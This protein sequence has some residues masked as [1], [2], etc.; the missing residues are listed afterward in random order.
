[1][2]KF[3]ALLTVLGLATLGLTGCMS[4]GAAGCTRPAPATPAL[5]GQFDISGDLG[6]TPS[7]TFDT[8][9]YVDEPQ[10]WETIEGT[11]IPI[12]SDNQ[13]V[14]LDVAVYDGSTGR[15]LVSTAFD[16]DPSRVFTIQD[17]TA[18]FPDFGDLMTCA[19]EGSRVAMALPYDGLSE[20]TAQG[21]GMSEG[22]S[23]LVVA[24]VTKAFLTR[25]TG[26][27]VFNNAHNLPTVVRAPSGQPGIIVPDAPAPD[28]IV[29]QTII[30]GDGAVLTADDTVRVNYTGVPWQVDGD[31][32]HTTWGD[33]PESVTV[34][35]AQQPGFTDALTDQTVG[36]QVLLVVPADQSGSDKAAVYVIDI[37][38]T[39]V[40]AP[41]PQ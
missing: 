34:G 1:M 25:A 17:W 22:D 23:V 13:L 4:V 24:D 41:A 18:T 14:A 8:P 26:T 21:L 11:G 38:G 35:T 5:Q 27:T 15:S 33:S 29:V 28:E 36:S 37:L 16:G 32:L 6:S 39:D 2:R 12:T 30:R 19:A 10:T 7:V 9:F 20:Q 31:V 40:A 3:P